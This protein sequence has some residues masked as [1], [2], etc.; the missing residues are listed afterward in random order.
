[1]SNL[2]FLLRPLVGSRLAPLTT[3]ISALAVDGQ[4]LAWVFRSGDVVFGVTTVLLG[5]GVAAGPAPWRRGW[6]PWG[7]GRDAA[8]WLAA[9][10]VLSGAANAVAAAV[11]ETSTSDLDGSALLGSAADATHG[12]ASLLAGMGLVL[13]AVACARG[14]GR[15]GRDHRRATVLFATSLAVV[16][17]ALSVAE[18][19]GA[20]L[21]TIPASGAV[22]RVQ[23][24][25]SSVWTVLVGV[26]LGRAGD[27]GP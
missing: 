3:E 24:L 6:D 4:P 7:S 27:R 13:A 1:M 21:G 20:V 23:V 22:Q 18:A 2:T 12:L 25:A 5:I 9:G 11:P 8:W 15:P 26:L 16:L 10:M 17:V 19:L 14:L